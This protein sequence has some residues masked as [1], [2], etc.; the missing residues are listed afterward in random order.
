[1]FATVG[2]RYDYASAFGENAG[3]VFY[4]KLSVS[5]VPSDRPSWSAPLG[6]NTF[7]V[8]AAIGQS[9]RQ[10]D[11]FAKFTTYAPLTF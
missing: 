5:I 8:R 9:G 3:G 10:P 2:G 7:R 1:M 4:P 11:A 6:M